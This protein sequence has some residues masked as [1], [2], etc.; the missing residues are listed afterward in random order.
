MIYQNYNQGYNYVQ[1]V[2]PISYPINY[3]N[4]LNQPFGYPQMYPI[5]PL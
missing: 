3:I 1:Q 5:D 2:P 4:N